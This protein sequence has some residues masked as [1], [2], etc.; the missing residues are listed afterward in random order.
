MS[1]TWN[2]LMDVAVVFGTVARGCVDGRR[3]ALT[4]LVAEALYA[5]VRAP[6][7]GPRPCTDLD[8]YVRGMAI[9]EARIMTIVECQ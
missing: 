8:R 6:L 5:Y 1:S 7:R 2:T 4:G 9:L 3:R